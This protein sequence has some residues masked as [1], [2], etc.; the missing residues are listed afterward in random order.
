MNYNHNNTR[1]RVPNKTSRNI[2][3]SDVSLPNPTRK[4][5]TDDG[6][7]PWILKNSKHQKKQKIYKLT[8][9]S[10]ST[11]NISTYNVRSLKEDWKQ[12]ELVSKASQFNLP[13]IAIQ[14]HRINNKPTIAMA[15]FK[16]LLAPPMKNKRKATIGGLG[17]L[18]SPWAQ[19]CFIDQTI[20]SDRIMSVSFCG[21][22][23]TH[24]INYHSPTNVAS[25]IEIETFY[26]E[27]SDFIHTIPPHDLII[28]AADANAHLGRDLCSKNAFYPT[29]NRNGKL[30]HDFC[31]EHNLTPG[32]PKFC[33]R[34]SKKVTWIAPNG[35][36]HQNDHILIRS[37][38]QNSLKNIESYIAPNVNSDH[39]IVT[40]CIKMSFRTNKCGHSAPSYDWKSLKTNDN[41]AVQFNCHFTKHFS[42]LTDNCDSELDD[43]YYQK[44][45]SAMIDSINV[46]A[47]AS[48]PPKGKSGLKYEI[49]NNQEFKAA[50][51][52][53]DQVAKRANQR[54]TRAATKELREA[55][56]ALR[57]IETK[58]QQ[59]HVNKT[60]GMIDINL[61]AKS[62]S[63]GVAWKLV[64]DLTGRKPRSLD[65]LKGYTSKQ[66]RLKAWNS[67]YS[68]LLYNPSVT[69]HL[70]NIE[71]K[72]PLPISTDPISSDE[73]NTALKQLRDTYGHDGI[74][75]FIYK[76]IDVEDKLLPILN[77]ILYSGTPP[78]ELLI[79]AIL[80]IP[81]GNSLFTPSNSRGISIL[82]VVTKLFNRILLNR[83]REH[84][85][86]LL[87][88]NQNGFRPGRGTREH[89]LTLRRIIEEAINHQL[90][91]VISFIDFSKAFD[92]IVR[93]HLPDILA[94]YRIPKAII[95]AIMALY[96]NT[97]AKVLT[98]EGT[99]LEFLTN[100]GILQGDVL[101]PLLFIIVLDYILRNSIN[102]DSPGLVISPGSINSP[103]TPEIKLSDLEFADDIATLTNTLE[104]STI[105][106][107]RIADTA[108]LYGL[109][110][111]LSKTKYMA[112]NHTR[113]MRYTD[114]VTVNGSRLDEVPDFKYLGAY[115]ASTAHDI[116]VR[117]ALSWTAMN[118]LDV[119]WKSDLPR[120]TKTKIFRTAVEPVLLYGAETWTLKESQNK[121]LDGTTPAFSAGLLTSHGSLTPPMLSYMAIFPLFPLQSGN[122]G[123]NSLDTFTVIKISR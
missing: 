94:E 108:A 69:I 100:L 53:R 117:K 35:D 45:Y 30:L 67:H 42:T 2:A 47:K 15:G 8:K 116:S 92:S 51:K 88:Y 23:T 106:C 96:I 3:H 37:K 121:E 41:L 29:S 66:Q 52:H 1:V 16:F 6:Y 54:K 81:K 32:F 86:P 28:V 102:S 4:G 5:A 103:I 99:T 79:T 78:S 90:P 49:L 85:E 20:V 101:A 63:A 50:Q 112:L 118:S 19:K 21:T 46:A 27:L 62:N 44:S 7:T 17:F 55:T 34:N 98:P 58:L 120:N 110:F 13:I 38:W 73:Y 97:K 40:A 82:P 24:I 70:N 123:S 84:V 114:T 56:V 89:I 83:I 111:N 72:D 61:S 109:H 22:L 64:N 59:D 74:P 57:E 91:C 36:Q 26:N 48:L 43:N 33:K 68:Q 95:K 39:R 93:S 25:D 122:V 60:I 76:I 113:P 18:L 75:S 65:I 115:I 104:E 80:P 77:N 12:W 107:Q 119:F 14:E 87:R 10:N 71:V 11:L 9:N 105:L 31:S